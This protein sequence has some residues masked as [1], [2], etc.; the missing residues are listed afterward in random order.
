MD[1]KIKDKIAIVTGGG[2]GIGRAIALRLANEGAK[3]VVADL[4]KDAAQKVA[5]EIKAQGGDG[6]AI[7]C[8]ATS[9]GDVD[10]MVRETLTAYGVIDIL[11]NN[12]GGGSGTAY[13]AETLVDNW[14]K[15]IDINLKSAFLCCRAAA[16]VMIKRKQGRIVS[17]S[18]ISGKTGEPLIGAYCAAKFG[19]IGLTQVLAR[20]LAHYDITVNVVCPGYVYTPGWEKLAQSLKDNHPSLANKSLPEVFEARVKSVTPLGRPQTADDV[21][22]LVAYLSSQEAKNITGQAINVDGGAFMG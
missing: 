7:G 4:K 17:I 10:A 21:A 9:P 20:E 15:T 12:A 1:L 22:S 8:D 13:V 11:V 5:E 19:V 2:S 18:S 16:Q 6:L 14:D 3:V